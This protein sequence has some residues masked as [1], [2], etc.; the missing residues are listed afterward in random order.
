MTEH[1]IVIGS[2]GSR[3]AV[4]Q[5]EMVRDFIREKKPGCQVEIL[6]MKTTGDKILDRTLEKIGGKGLFVKELDKA[7]L[8]GCS[9][10]SVHSLKDMP[11]ELSEELPLLAFSKREDPRDVLVL[12]EGAEKWDRTLP[13]GC[14]SQRRM[15][16]LKEL[17]PDVT[18]LPVRGN[19]QTRLQKLQSG[20]YGALILAAAGLKRLGLE[21]R[22]YRYFEPDEIIPAAGQGILAVQGRKGEDY[23]FLKAYNDPAA[24]TAQAAERAFVK[25]LNGGCSSPIAAYAEMKNGKLLLRGLYYQEA[26]GIYKKG[27]IEGNPEDAETMGM[28][29]AEGLKKECH[30]QSCTAVKEDDIKPGKVWLVGAGPSDPGLFTLKGKRVLQKAEVVVYDALA[31]QAILS[32]IPEDAEKINVGKRASHHLMPQEEINKIL[33]K[34]ALEGKRVVRLKGGDPF[35]FG[36]G[37][38]ELELLKAHQIPY[39]VVPGVTSAIAVPAYNGIP[40]THRDFCSSVHIITGHKKKGDTYDI[41]FEAL[42]RTKGTLVFLMGVT[43]LADICDGLLKAGM[44][45]DM[46]VAILQQGTTA[47]QKRISATVSTLPE[48]VQKQGIQTPA[49]IVVGEVCALADRFAWHEALPLAGRKILVTRPKELISQM[50]E[51]LRREGAE[52]LELP[53]IKTEAI[54]ENQKLKQSMEAIH[55]YD[56][57]VFT[58]PTGVR[59]FFEKLAEHEADIRKLAAAKFAVIGSGSEKELKKHGIL[60]DLKPEIFDGEHLGSSLARACTGGERILIPRAETAN[61]ELILELQKVPDVQIDDVPTYRTLYESSELIDQKAEFE[62]GKIDFVVFTSASTV[63]GFA[64][65]AKGLDFSLVRAVCIGKQT[66]QAADEL[67]MQ[68]WMSEKATMDS[69][70][71]KVKELC[72]KQ[73]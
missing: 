47:G 59:V 69:V 46:P 57:I 31:G 22:I 35:L 16:Q 1:N 33:V 29:L 45:A 9:D 55:S 50:A 42:V 44:R 71:D 48:E 18:F 5:S 2:R 25:Y 15:L 37:G 68:S 51:K 8:D 43:A 23:A 21:N 53:A 64:Q 62:Q 39:E 34:K 70:L 40:V 11:M 26:T 4:I 52:V 38:E 13:V 28:L 49:I 66:K 58:S 60:A 32:M 72:R 67:G 30:A 14:S 3:L 17:Y 12:P 36:R 24:Q 61:Q 73:L 41:D 7:L 6:T 19:I 63:R 54:S 27:Q 56:W 10:L 20:A 65:A